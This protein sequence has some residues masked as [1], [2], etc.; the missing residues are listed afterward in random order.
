MAND[1]PM[2]SREIRILTPFRGGALDRVLERAP[3]ARVIV[4]PEH[5]EPP[6][7]AHGEVLLIP[8]WD[9]GNLRAVLERGVRWIHTIGTGVDRFPFELLGDRIL[10]C[11]RG[12]SAIPIAE[13][14]VAVMLAFEKRL[15]EAWVHE[16]PETWSVGFHLGGLH[17]KTLGLVGLGGI[18][19]GVA[20]RVLPFGMRVRALRRTSKASDLAGVETVGDL[21]DLLSSADHVVLAVPLTAATRHVI[22][23]RAL[24]QVKRGAH[25]VNVSRGALVDHD[26]L[27]EALDDGRIACA[28][29]DVTDPEPLPAGHWLYAHPQVRLSPH[30]SWN[31]PGAFDILLDG[32]VDNLLRY[33]A[34]EALE[35]RVDLEEGY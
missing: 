19:L 8:P 28:S 31:M 1:G 4:I 25:L 24:A 32:F 35:G 27:R 10:T 2:A 21:A 15:P 13:W 17:G 9:T 11:A 23:R 26:A 30:V 16:P 22:D 18:G 6:A 5:G 14:V 34:G 20:R 29:L 7:D 3:D 12:A 33:Q